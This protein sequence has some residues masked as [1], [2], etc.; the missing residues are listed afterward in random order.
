VI[1]L[2]AGLGLT[3]GAPEQQDNTFFRIE[4]I[5][6]GLKL[7]VTRVCPVA[8]EVIDMLAGKAP[9]TVISAS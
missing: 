6:Y 1:R 3:A 5:S 8:R 9:R 7:T 4:L 2:I